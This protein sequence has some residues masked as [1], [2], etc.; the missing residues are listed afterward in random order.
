M[1]QSEFYER[2]GVTLSGEEYAKVERVYDYVKMDKDHFC[3]EWLKIRSSA[4]FDETMDAFEALEKENFSLKDEISSLKSKIEQYKVECE[5]EIT[6]TQEQYLRKVN[7]LGKK[8][9]ANIDDE[10]RIYDILEE[11]FTLDFIIRAKLEGNLDLMQHEREHLIK[12]LSL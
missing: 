11:E 9:I 7:D 2:T 1:L 12:K 5:N 6:K 10:T 3:E 8:I 4:L